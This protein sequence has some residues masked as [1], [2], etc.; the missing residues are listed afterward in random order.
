MVLKWR[1]T[2]L[3]I[4]AFVWVSPS[5]FG[6]DY[7]HE[8]WSTACNETKGFHD[9]DTLTC[10]SGTRGSFVVRFAGIDAPETGQA[11]WKASRDL[12]RELAI[13]G[14]HAECYK[15]DAYGREV[16]RLKSPSGDDLAEAM[17]QRGMAWHAVRYAHEQ[18][19]TE[20]TRYS[21]LA[22]EARSA[23]VGLWSDPN[24]LSP[25]DCRQIR[26]KGHKCR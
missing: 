13:P 7:R 4:F 22:A 11:F 3:F 8:L 20:R 6:S 9:G 2:L 17:L 10:V 21:A 23:K 26:S 19:I 14:T 1:A 12:L 5:A 18:T 16:C 25:W 15:Q 24:P